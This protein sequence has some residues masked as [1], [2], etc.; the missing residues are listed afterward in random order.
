MADTFTYS[1]IRVVPDRRRGEW[2]NA[3]VVVYLRDRLDI[4]LHGN[5]SKLRAMAPALD[6]AFLQTLPAAWERLCEGEDSIDERQALLSRLP[7][8]HASPAGQF[9]A[10]AGTYEQQ[11]QSILQDLVAPPPAPSRKA[12]PTRLETMLK[13]HFQRARL[14]GNGAEDIHRHL[15]VPRYPIDSSARLYADFALRNGKLRLTE[16]IDFRVSLEQMRHRHGLAALKSVTLNRA[17]A[18]H[19]GDCVPSVVYAARTED[20]DLIQ[21][22]LNMLG[23]YADRLYDANNESDMADYMSMMASAAAH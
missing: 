4:R 23:D 15:V 9:C 10:D 7:L 18:L 13:A 1:L 22:S 12:L 16:T 6:T 17:A 21:H 2:V 3:G 5:Y 14:L 19:G 20:L 8:A 11:V